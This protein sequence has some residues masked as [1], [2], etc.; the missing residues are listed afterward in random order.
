VPLASVFDPRADKRFLETLFVDSTGL[1]GSIREFL[2]YPRSSLPRNFLLTGPPGA[3]KSTL[4]TC[5]SLGLEK[6]LSADKPLPGPLYVPVLF[7]ERETDVFDLQ[8]AWKR[9]REL[10][11]ES[12]IRKYP[13]EAGAFIEA[14]LSERTDPRG[15]LERAHAANIRI[16]L[17]LDNFEQF[18][19]QSDEVFPLEDLKVLL[20]DQSPLTVG[21]TTYD[22]ESISARLSGGAGEVSALRGFFQEFQ[23]PE[24]G[25]PEAEALLNKCLEMVGEDSRA[26]EE[27][28][29]RL[30]A[31]I[32]LAGGLPR[33][34]QI[35]FQRVLLPK[36]LERIAGAPSRQPDD[37][38]AQ[39]DMFKKVLDDR[40][41]QH[42]LDKLPSLEARVLRKVAEKG[43]RC[44][45]VEVAEAM[46][47]SQSKIGSCFAR[48][49]EKG[50][51]GARG[52]Q[53]DGDRKRRL[54]SFRDPMLWLYCLHN[55]VGSDY[56]AEA[57]RAVTV[58]IWFEQPK[59]QSTP[60]TA[61]WSHS[62]PS[63]AS[64]SFP[65]QSGAPLHREVSELQA[66][67][68]F[69]A[70]RALVEEQCQFVR[71]SW[72]SN[73]DRS[74]DHG[75]DSFAFA[76]SF[77]LDVAGEF[78]L[79]ERSPDGQRDALSPAEEADLRDL[80]AGS[81][82]LTAAEKG[83]IID[84]YPRLTRDQIDELLRIFLEERT[85]FDSL[86]SDERLR[87]QIRSLSVRAGVEWVKLAWK[88]RGI[89]EKGYVQ[90]IVERFSRIRNMEVRR[91]FLVLLSETLSQWGRDARGAYRIEES[92]E[93]M[94]GVRSVAVLLGEKDAEIDAL[95]HLSWQVGFEGGFERAII[96]AGEA[97]D[98]ALVTGNEDLQGRALVRLAD[99]FRISGRYSEAASYYEQA[100]T[101]FQETEN[102]EGL[103]ASMRKRAELLDDLE[104][105]EALRERHPDTG[106]LSLSISRGLRRRGQL[107]RASEE[108]GN[109][110]KCARDAGDRLLEGH[111]LLEMAYVRTGAGKLT[112]ASD[113]CLSARSVYEAIHDPLGIANCEQQLA[114]IKGETAPPQEAMAAFE[115][116][117]GLYA[118]L[119]GLAWSRPESLAE[120]GAF[121]TRLE[122]LPDAAS[123]LTEALSFYSASPITAGSAAEIQLDL[124]RV[125]RKMGDISRSREFCE[126]AEEL[127]RARGYLPLL[128]DCIIENVLR[129][130]ASPEPDWDSLH[131]AWTEWLSL[132]KQLILNGRNVSDEL[133][134]TFISPLKTL[135]IA[136]R[137]REE[138]IRQA[139]RLVE[140]ARR[141][142]S[143]EPVSSRRSE[144]IPNR[145][146][147]AGLISIAEPVVLAIEWAASGH[148]EDIL[149]WA[150]PHIYS[151][152]RGVIVEAGEIPPPLRK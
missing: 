49:Q 103:L 25:V 95:C 131:A 67:T 33:N 130:L 117:E 37:A 88:R 129:E 34:V 127:F 28:K 112:D 118:S 30:K 85:K 76:A 6:E 1:L 152:V 29:V 123:A 16:L 70:E 91:E 84:A 87:R 26:T 142:L 69:R 73:F 31:F 79:P 77:L 109:A 133:V 139:G 110:L 108:S 4:L 113:L 80:V 82:S 97:R 122:R 35:L 65:S 13:G 42:V 98:L 17:L 5:I 27:M 151:A 44:S 52:K 72:K 144:V 53:P 93:Y 68:K 149:E 12:P 140:A 111:A 134:A 120:R 125:Y 75:E 46:D 8:S 116:V 47:Q 57:V 23:L 63:E 18:F 143:D 41:W 56:L 62:G 101:R 15:L 89:P 55:L 138:S 20:G 21:A 78:S 83:A 58:E 64:E 9:T 99:L 147:P 71:E 14:A 121:L 51:L 59:N 114:T 90:A 81:V 92:T 132:Q 107:A 36:L 141:I 45:A 22:A 94:E 100:I 126:K 135:L 106:W 150:P 60:V 96:L 137:N 54:Y 146:V 104:E 136:G 48:L 50:F 7:P 86:S 119:K 102:G 74:E 19:L 3:G 39:L 66:F 148:K 128:A 40:H 2:S 105:L 11:Q 43:G 145:E 124:A 38:S 32:S 10:L 115:T 24:F 61:A